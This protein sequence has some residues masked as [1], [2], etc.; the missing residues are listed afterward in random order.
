MTDDVAALKRNTH[1]TCGTRP[2]RRRRRRSLCLR[3]SAFLLGMRISMET[4]QRQSSPKKIWDKSRKIA[5]SAQMA[6]RNGGG[7]PWRE[8]EQEQQYHRLH[9]PWHYDLASTWPSRCL[10]LL[11]HSLTPPFIATRSKRQTKSFA[12]NEEERGGASSEY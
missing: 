6:K 4:R 12:V 10:Q 7:L 3:F 9:V 1:T 8:E 11:T 5:F 2:K